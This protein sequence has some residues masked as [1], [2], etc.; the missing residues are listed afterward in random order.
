MRLHGLVGL[1]N[2]YPV[3]FLKQVTNLP[4]DLDQLV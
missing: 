4:K 2:D 1:L 3:A